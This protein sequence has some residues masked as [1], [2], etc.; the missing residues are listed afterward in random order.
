[1]NLIDQNNPVVKLCNEGTFAEFEKR[2]DSAQVLYQRA[3]N[4]ATNDYERCIAAHYMARTQLNSESIFKWN[5]ASLRFAE[6]SMDNRVQSFF[7]S[8]YVNM[9]KSCELMGN[10]SEAERFYGLAA[11]LGLIH[12]K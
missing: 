9:G 6:S 5:E 12:Q 11:E 3:W 8:L 1:L 7:P 4:L 10:L 2:F